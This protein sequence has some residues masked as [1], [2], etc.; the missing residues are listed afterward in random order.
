MTFQQQ[1]IRAFAERIAYKENIDANGATAEAAEL[2]LCRRDFFH[3]LKYWV[4]TFDPREDVAVRPFV[5]W[6]KQMEFFH[7]LF[8]LDKTKQSGLAPKSRDTGVTWMVLIQRSWKWRFQRDYTG[9][10]GSRKLELVD[11]RGSHRTLFEKIR[12]I[13]RNVPDWMLPKGF[14]WQKHDLECLFINPEMNSSFNGEGGDNIGHG[15]RSTDFLVDEA[16]RLEHQ[17]MADTGLA[18]TTNVR[19]DISTPNGAGGSFYRRVHSGEFPVFYLSWRDDPRKD[20]EW[21]RKKRAELGSTIFAE[22]YDIDFTASLEGLCI[23][24]KWVRAAIDLALP[25]QAGPIVCGFDVGGGKET[26]DPCVVIPRQGPKV[27]WPADW[28]GWEEVQ[29]VWRA[30]D[31]VVKQKGK[32]CLYDASGIGSFVKGEW[33]KGGGVPFQVI[34]VNTGSHPSELW[35]PDEETSKDKFLNLRAELWFLMRRRFEK[36]YEFVME[37]VKHPLH[38]LISIPNHP[39]LIQELSNVKYS[40]QGQ[41]SKIVMESKKELKKR[42]VKSPDFADALAL[43]FAGEGQ[44]WYDPLADSKGSIMQTAPREIWVLPAGEDDDRIPDPPGAVTLWSAGGN[45]PDS[46]WGNW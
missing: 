1:I 26:S 16:A 25:D 18:A 29:S 36:T 32:A 43:T 34:P 39:Q 46:Q 6:P 3:W 41:G 21:A 28:Q 31:E 27:G 8:M 37:G 5:P 7:W 42:G 13:W 11:K 17:E 4:W 15:D 30:R 10:L 38:E 19:V 9:G 12:F 33:D 45:Q 24:A 44:E 40:R 20:E 35:W 22:Q 2:E 14:D 23:P